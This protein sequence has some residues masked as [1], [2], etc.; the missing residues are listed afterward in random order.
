MN[1]KYHMISEI[2]KVAYNKCLTNKP[3]GYKKLGYY[4]LPRLRVRRLN[5]IK[6]KHEIKTIF[7][8]EIHK[9]FDF[10]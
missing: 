9:I 1:L 10:S 4:K 6:S 7:D 3:V 8:H 2:V 5:F